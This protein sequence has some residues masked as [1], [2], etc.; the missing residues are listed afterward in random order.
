MQMSCSLRP[1]CIFLSFLLFGKQNKTLS[2][3]LPN[4]GS[5]VWLAHWVSPGK[6]ER[7]C[8]NHQLHSVR[9]LHGEWVFEACHWWAGQEVGLAT[10]CTSVWWSGFSP[11]LLSHLSLFILKYSLSFH[12]VHVYD[13]RQPLPALQLVGHS[14]SVLSVQMDE[15]KVVSGR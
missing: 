4:S 11:T 9:W 12:R 8:F 2:P 3:S 1:P 5:I 7:S 13:A 10:S 6:L 15:W 14:D